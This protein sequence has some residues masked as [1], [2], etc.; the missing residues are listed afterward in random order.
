M[1]IGRLRP[2][3]RS[4]ESESNEDHRLE[5]RPG[6]ANFHEIAGVEFTDENGGAPGLGYESDI[7]EALAR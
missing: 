1:A 4:L 6:A 5:V 2:A 3:A 7:R